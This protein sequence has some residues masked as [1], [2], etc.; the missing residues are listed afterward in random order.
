MKCP[1]R[2]ENRR[3][4]HEIQRIEKDRGED[5]RQHEWVDASHTFIIG[6]AE[7]QRSSDAATTTRDGDAL[8]EPR[9]IEPLSTSMIPRLLRV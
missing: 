4:N 6:S 2:R 1:E 3:A 7:R 8:V 5:Q 9:G